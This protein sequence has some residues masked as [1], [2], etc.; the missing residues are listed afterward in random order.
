[1]L[2]LLP[3]SLGITYLLSSLGVY[4]RDL[5]HFI[6]TAIPGLLFLSP[7]FYPVKALPEWLQS[8]MFFNPVAFPV[9]ELRNVILFSKSPDFTL[10]LVNIIYGIVVFILGYYVFKKSQ[11]GFADVI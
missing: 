11:K 3:I 1:L 7:I 4:I 9:E 10:A 5:S 2:T 8:F 6:I